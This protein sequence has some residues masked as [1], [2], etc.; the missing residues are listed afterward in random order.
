MRE[1]EQ[2]YTVFI[3]GAWY[4]QASYFVFEKMKLEGFA[5][6]DDVRLKTA[7][8][9]PRAVVGRIIGKGG[10]TVKDIQH[11]TGVI[12]KLPSNTAEEAEEAQEQEDEVFVTVYGNFLTTQVLISV[13]LVKSTETRSHK[14]CSLT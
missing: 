8:K 5:G 7:I 2:Q 14:I 12:I 6:Y 9:V 13:I 10:K 4:M 3:C 1:N 11:S